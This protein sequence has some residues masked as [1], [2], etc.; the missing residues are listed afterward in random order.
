[1]AT[2]CGAISANITNDCEKAPSGGLEKTVTLINHEDILS[3]STATGDKLIVNDIN[4]KTGTQAY[5]WTVIGNTSNA[6]KFDVVKKDWGGKMF[7]H[8]LTTVVTE[9]STTNKQSIN[10]MK[11]GL[12]VAIITNR[13][14]INDTKYEVLGLN[15]G[16]ELSALAWDTA[17]D[18]GIYKITLASEDGQEEPYIPATFQVNGQ[19]GT[20]DPAATAS[21]LT[22]LLTPA[23]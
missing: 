5:T 7:T 10:N 1:M 15:S 11:D 6:A 16:L 4:L 2:I 21:A 12:Y 17:S 18:D 3:V 8:T 19:G 23:T 20:Y 14:N 9:K 22:A 13:S